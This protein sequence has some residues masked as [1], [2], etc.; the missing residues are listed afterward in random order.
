MQKGSGDSSGGKSGDSSDDYG[1]SPS[2]EVD[3]ELVISGDNV[4]GS[5]AARGVPVG[6]AA[7]VVAVTPTLFRPLVAHPVA[8]APRERSPG[9]L[10][11]E[12]SQPQT[13]MMGSPGL[14]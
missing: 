9:V 12:A 2:L 8:E 3:R 11:V 13:Q 1:T 7:M 14:G 5:G 6:A 10:T 4:V